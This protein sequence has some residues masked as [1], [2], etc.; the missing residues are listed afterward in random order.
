MFADDTAVTGARW[1]L[2]PTERA[3]DFCGRKPSGFWDFGCGRIVRM[4]EEEKKKDPEAP[5][6]L[7][8]RPYR[9]S[10]HS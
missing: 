8:E 10:I 7:V 5:P 3:A 4:A 9:N 2:R 1:S 6:E